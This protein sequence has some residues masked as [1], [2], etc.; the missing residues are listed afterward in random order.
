[1]VIPI[2]IISI[3]VLSAFNISVVDFPSISLFIQLGLLCHLRIVGNHSAGGF[4][5]HIHINNESG[6]FQ[7]FKVVRTYFT[8]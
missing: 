6:I 4:F 1:M 8:S 3:L 2:I 5:H 7:Q